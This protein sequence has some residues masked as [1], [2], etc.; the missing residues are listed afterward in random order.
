[1]SKRWIALGMAPLAALAISAA[2]ALG[3]GSVS[4][5]KAPTAA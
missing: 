2:P 4:K 3:G 1:M 5:Q